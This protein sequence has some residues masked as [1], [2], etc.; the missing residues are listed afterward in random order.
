M[1]AAGPPPVLVTGMPRSGTTLVG[2][3]LARHPG[4][5][6]IWEPFNR[7]YR[8]GVPDYYPYVGASTPASK[9]ETYVGLLEDT[10]ALRLRG[11]PVG[12]NRSGGGKRALGRVLR[13]SRTDLRYRRLGLVDRFR[14]R[15]VRLIKDPV[16]AFLAELSIQVA[17]CK[18][19]V[20]TRHPAA[21]FDSFQTR[22]WGA[23][24]INGLLSQPD[25]RSDLFAPGEAADLEST[26]VGA[27]RFGLRYRVTYRYLREVAAR[28]PGAVTF[29]D[30]RE[31]VDDPEATVARLV[32]FLDWGEPEPFIEAMR[33]YLSGS[34]TAHRG[35]DL[36]SVQRRDAA[37]T[38]T[39]WR[40]RLSESDVEAV[41][42]GAGRDA[43]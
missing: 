13:T 33:D 40:R 39:G 10:L 24:D 34:S 32:D 3:V 22:G 28:H 25:A 17:S 41:L 2:H 16:G 21:V 37:A 38:V 26:T 23:G 27:Y 6:E 7:R 36:A 29:V 5:V 19:V 14:H 31:V 8:R 30:H 9:R 11:V 15:P 20:C 4:A 42:R 1:T 43:G 18:V 12:A 35:R